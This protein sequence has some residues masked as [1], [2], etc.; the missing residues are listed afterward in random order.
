[1]CFWL[2][3][4]EVAAR[5]QVTLFLTAAAAASKFPSARHTETLDGL[6]E[7]EPEGPEGPLSSVESMAAGSIC[8]F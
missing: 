2:G 6:E 8:S 3:T 4:A 5:L 1:M 7:A